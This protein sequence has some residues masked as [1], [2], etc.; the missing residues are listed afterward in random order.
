MS[1][2]LRIRDYILL[3][4]AGVYD[5]LNNFP[6]KGYSE[7]VR[8]LDYWPLLPP[9][10][11]KISYYSEVSRL[12]ST[13]DIKRK[14]NKKG[15]V[16]LE[17]T[18]KGER[19]FKRRFSLLLMS[20][21]KWDRNFMVVT[22]DIPEELSYI[23]QRLRDKLKSLG[24][25]MFQKSVWISSYHLEEDLQEFIENN[26]LSDFVSVFTARK[27]F[28]ESLKNLAKRIWK[29]EKL[30]KKYKSVIQIIM[31]PQNK[32]GRKDKSNVKKARKIYLQTLTTDP[33]L[34]KE[35]L[36][37]DWARQRA[38]ELLKKKTV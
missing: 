13:G 19:E 7:T 22:Y 30:N 29:L 11:K 14:V 2:L 32:K 38:L 5:V 8:N 21:K 12:L 20:T 37:S 4:S 28:G 27:L 34:P 17:L 23:R 26:G 24:F 3:S 15:E 18:A 6:I 31:R 25:G 9:E 1:K 36:P 16:I 10:R 33:L 35:L